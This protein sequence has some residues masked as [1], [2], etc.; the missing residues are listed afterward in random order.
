MRRPEAKFA[1]PMSAS[2]ATQLGHAIRYARL[3]RNLTQEDFAQRARVS[4]ATLQRIERGDPA[5]SFTSWLSAM[6]ASSLLPVLKAAAQAS[7]DAHGSA[8]RQMEQRQR[9]S[10]PRSSASDRLDAYAF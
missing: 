4:I 2:V 8:L 9:A 1:S 6:E 3:G 7:A 10:K 5:V